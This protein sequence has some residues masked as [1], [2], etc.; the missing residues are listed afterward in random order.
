MCPANP[1]AAVNSVASEWR[2]PLGRPVVPDV[3]YTHRT[4]SAACGP[5]SSGCGN[6]GIA[7]SC[8]R[9]SFGSVRTR[10][11]APAFAAVVRS[12]TRISASATS[13][14]D[15]NLA[16]TVEVQYRR[17]LN[18]DA[19]QRQHQHRRA[20][21]RRQLPGDR[22]PGPHTGVPEPV[23]WRPTS[24]PR[25]QRRSASGRRCRATAVDPVGWRRTRREAR[26]WCRPSCQPIRRPGVNFTG[27]L[28]TA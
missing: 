27:S 9:K 20:Q 12:T 24:G 2:T 17:L 1:R 4:S 3:K 6:C 19:R 15:A 18:I 16:A 23:E 11:P 8:R 26:R 13:T 7:R 28:D 5:F 10:A 25:R 21:M 22:H 14:A